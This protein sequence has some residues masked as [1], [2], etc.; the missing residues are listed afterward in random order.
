MY[1]LVMCSWLYSIKTYN[2]LQLV[3]MHL[4]AIKYTKHA[5]NSVFQMGISVFIWSLGPPQL[6]LAEFGLVRNLIHC[7]K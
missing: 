2:T 1:V 7:I 4:K 6:R 3:R 5:L